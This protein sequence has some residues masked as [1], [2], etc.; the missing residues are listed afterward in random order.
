ME[1]N[2][3]FIYSKLVKKNEDLIGHIAYSLYKKS[4]IEYIE[5]IK[6]CD[7]D[8]FFVANFIDGTIQCID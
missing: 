8:A 5:K 3:N 1:R 2:Y 4:K 6:F 7:R